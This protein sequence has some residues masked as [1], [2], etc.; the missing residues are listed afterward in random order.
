MHRSDY[1]ISGTWARRKKTARVA[2]PGVTT[3]SIIDMV[4]TRS[5]RARAA[6]PSEAERLDDALK[7]ATTPWPVECWTQG[8]KDVADDPIATWHMRGVSIAIAS[9]VYDITSKRISSAGQLGDWISA[10]KENIVSFAQATPRSWQHTHFGADL[11]GHR[12]RL[13]SRVA[14]SQVEGH[15]RVAYRHRNRDD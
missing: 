6:G 13:L 2:V 7:S 9:L 14:S 3:S 10:A 1:V 5:Q 15:D 11:A 4:E 12:H 8:W